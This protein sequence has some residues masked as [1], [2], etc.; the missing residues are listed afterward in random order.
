MKDKQ[1]NQ[2][3]VFELL[4]GSVYTYFETTS[5]VCASSCANLKLWQWV[6]SLQGLRRYTNRRLLKLFA[7]RTTS[8]HLGQTVLK[9]RRVNKFVFTVSNSDV[10]W[11]CHVLSVLARV[12]ALLAPC[13]HSLQ[14][15]QVPQVCNYNN[16]NSASLCVTA[17][18][19]Y[20]SKLV[21]FC[22]D[23]KATPANV[24]IIGYKQESRLLLCRLQEQ[25]GNNTWN[26]M[27]KPSS[28]CLFTWLR[29]K[30]LGFWM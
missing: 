22:L 1:L 15:T 12:A 4:T 24:I 14:V 21:V 27:Y 25:T 10:R 8:V 11:S 9:R 30:A 28:K 2:K 19:Q 6:V 17:N 5:G 26:C 13:S 20:R 16:N 18:R 3:C 29:R 7:E 23:R